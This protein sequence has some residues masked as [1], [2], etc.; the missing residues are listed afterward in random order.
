MNNF[1]KIAQSRYR[2][3]L[4]SIN[5]EDD[6]YN[7]VSDMTRNERLLLDPG[8]KLEREETGM[9]KAKIKKSLSERLFNKPRYA[10]KYDK[11]Y[12]SSLKDLTPEEIKL[13]KD[14]MEERLDDKW[15]LSRRLRRSQNYTPMHYKTDLHNPEEYVDLIHGTNKAKARAF[16]RGGNGGSLLEGPAYLGNSKFNDMGIQVHSLNKTRAKLYAEKQ[17]NGRG[18][19]PAILTGKIKRKYLYPNINQAHNGE[20]HS[21]E[22]GLP[23]ELFKKI[24]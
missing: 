10:P 9:D 4:D 24:E 23:E 15:L 18:G 2:K 13:R 19:T 14:R 21:D 7:A 20:V 16:L 12:N 8:N 6:L 11:A 3:Y 22:Y 5:N 17:S 1:E